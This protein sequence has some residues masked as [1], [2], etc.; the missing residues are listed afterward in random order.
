MHIS[1]AHSGQRVSLT[2]FHFASNG[3]TSSQYCWRC[4][5]RVGARVLGQRARSKSGAGTQ[6]LMSIAGLRERVTRWRRYIPP[7]GGSRQSGII[8]LI[9]SLVGPPKIRVPNTAKS[10]VPGNL[11]FVECYVDIFVVEGVYTES[12]TSVVF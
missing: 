3:L 2:F 4:R 1:H 7:T 12:I 9:L 5:P 10:S 11:R 6:L 8:T